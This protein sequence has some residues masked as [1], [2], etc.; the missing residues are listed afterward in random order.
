MVAANRPI[1]WWVDISEPTVSAP[2]F[3][4]PVVVIQGDSINRSRIATVI[5]VPLTTSTKWADAPGNAMLSSK[6]TG[7]PKDT[8]ANGSQII[9]LD[10]RCHTERTGRLPAKKIELI[11]SGIDVIL[12]RQPS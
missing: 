8:V 2:G 12:G 1:I 3:R 5:Y 9:T 6:L 4:Q 10:K 11:L 7:L